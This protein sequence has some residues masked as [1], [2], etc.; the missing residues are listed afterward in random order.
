MRE[1]TGELNITVIVVMAIAALAAFLF[2]F[3]WPVYKQA[4]V[5]DESCS[6]AVCDVGHNSKGFA[7]CYIPGEASDKFECPYRG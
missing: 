1:A 4:Y 5:K 6:K 3:I 7:T 2:L